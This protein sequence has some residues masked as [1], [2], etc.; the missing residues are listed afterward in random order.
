MRRLAFRAVVLLV[1]LPALRAE[2]TKRA[3]ARALVARYVRE[4]ASRTD[5][6]AARVRRDPCGARFVSA[7]FWGKGLANSA[8]V[9]LNALALAV[10]S[11]RT[12]LVSDDNRFRAG[13]WRYLGAVDETW[14]TKKRVLE[15]FDAA[16]GCARCGGCVDAFPEATRDFFPVNRRCLASGNCGDGVR[17]LLC[18]AAFSDDDPPF[19]HVRSAV[20]WLAPLLLENARAG[21]QLKERL[22][23]LFAPGVNAWGLLYDALLAP[24]AG[25]ALDAVVEPRR[26]EGGLFD[27]GVHVRHRRYQ[28]RERVDAHAAACAARALAGLAKAT[29]FLA[30]DQPSRLGGLR[31][32][33]RAAAP[34]TAID[35]RSLNASSVPEAE[36]E[37]LRKLAR[38]DVKAV[39]AGRDW[40]EL[41]SERWASVADFLLLSSSRVVVG[42]LSSSFSE[43]AAAVASRRDGDAPPRRDFAAAPRPRRGSSEETGRGGDSATWLFD[44]IY[45]LEGDARTKYNWPRPEEYL[46]DKDETFRCLRG[47]AAWPL[48]QYVRLRPSTARAWIRNGGCG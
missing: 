48:P 46:R 12:L 15:A 30:T 10:V 18:G 17:W 29:V 34:D 22:K 2:S 8:N 23:T 14:P 31:K 41:A 24:R 5:D 28:P 32:R 47:D 38:T 33:I 7:D 40:G 1:V 20:T 36:R 35:F 11:N 44:P 3:R 19:V 43:L 37:R 42:T 21:P 39:R 4:H 6:V 45:H 13:F 9:A 26:P 16:G 25:A 27:V